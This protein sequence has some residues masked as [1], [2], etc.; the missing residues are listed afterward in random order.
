MGLMK[1][2]AITKASFKDLVIN[3][4]EEA[5]RIINDNSL[6]FASLFSLQS[7]IEKH[8]LCE[9]LNLRNRIALEISNDILRTP[10]NKRPLPCSSCDYIENASSVLKW[11]LATGY[12]D[13]EIDNEYDQVLDITAAILTKVYKDTS[14][15]S[16][17]VDMIFSRYR[18]GLLIN[19]LVWA[20]FEVRSPYSLIYI[21]NYLLSPHSKDVE[22]ANKLLKFIPDI[23]YR[24]GLGPHK[25]YT[26]F[27]NWIKENNLF[28]HYTGEGFQQSY[29]PTP[30]KVVLEAKYLYKIVSVDTGK[31]LEILTNQEY[32]SLMEFKKLERNTK[33]LLSTFSFHLHQSD[34]NS[35]YSWIHYPISEQITIAR[36]GIGGR[37]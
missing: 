27:L 10:Q 4:T 36:M 22:L 37:L 31:I 34:I 2:I 3:N 19:N 6:R 8:G 17:I 26:S 9:K 23:Y 12:K 35:W 15:L 20:F 18:Q 7:D 25:Q 21:A 28:L 32:Q 5:I 1:G 29:A 24:I 30:Y 16:V 11:M 13:D 33:I 14:M